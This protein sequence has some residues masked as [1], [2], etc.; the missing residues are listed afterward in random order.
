MQRLIA[1]VAVSAAIYSIDRPY[2][3][4]V[5]QEMTAL[6][7]P[8]QRVIVP[9]GVGNK[10]S[11]GI[12]LE[13]R[14]E[15]EPQRLKEIAH[16][17]E[18][19]AL[20]EE[21]KELALWLCRRTFCTFFQAANVLLPPGIWSKQPE[22]YSPGNVLPEV[23]CV[24]KSAKKQRILKTVFSAE[25]PMTAREIADAS[26]L[27]SIAPD[28]RQL[29]REELLICEHHF[30]QSGREKTIE[31]IS[32]A[33][34][35]EQWAVVLGKKLTA[36]QAAVRDCLLSQDKLP[37]REICYRTG[38]GEGV[39]K[40]LI[41]RQLLSAESFPVSRMP[42][43]PMTNEPPA[44]ILNEEQEKAFEGLRS[45]MNSGKPE[46][47]LLYGVT[48]SGKT[49]IYIKLIR[50]TLQKGKSA[51]LLVPEIALTPQM[52]QK[53]CQFFGDLVAVVHS[54]LTAAQRYEAYQR[55]SIGGAR[56]VIGTRTAVFSPVKDLGCIILDEEQEPS[57]KSDSDPRYHARDVAKYRAAEEK[58]LLLLGSATPSIESFF[59][60]KA[61][62]YHL[63]SLRSRY[64]NTPLPKTL[65]AD[66][67]GQ[68]RSGDPS[69]ISEMLQEELQTNLN[70][71]EQS[72]LFLN[73]RGSARMAACVDCGYIPMCENC[74]SA[75]TYHS[76]NNRLMCHLC[77]YS[78]PMIDTCPECGS[79]HIRLIGFGTQSVEDELQALLPGV[80]IL[81][82]DAD[83]T[84]GRASHEKLLSSFAKGEADILLGTQM[85]AKG[86]DF[87]NV[88]LVGVLDAD[89]SL[90]CGDF[91][92]QERTFSLLT[93]V[94]GRAGRREKPGRAVIQTYTPENPVILAASQQDYDAFY[95]QEI[96]TRRVLKA[97][98]FFE[99][100]V[101]RFSGEDEAAVHRSAARFAQ[102]LQEQLMSVG[103]AEKTV[104]GPVPAAVA[105][106]SRRYYDTVSFRGHSTP[107]SRAFTAK[108]L[109]A[110]QRIH[111]G[112]TAAVSADINPLY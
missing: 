88:T 48:G 89:L 57:Y 26:G 27:E 67:R 18:E 104:L 85:V 46:A 43:S 81:R 69:R 58:C 94:I 101:F 63:F 62:K 10:L 111:T 91:H 66:M 68:L 61:G 6:V 22:T 65:I 4:S 3:Y 103:D 20:S 52:V 53:F 92:A 59:A 64:Q 107:Q 15:S 16:V 54:G 2:D 42:V 5:P 12:I 33:L 110:A 39:V 60:A 30:R 45:L 95:G 35:P 70:N 84:E 74:A 98:P 47:A 19:I 13:L 71:G 31:M 50:E 38:V 44:L 40:T 83:T 105:R 78:R 86:L 21:Q 24:G 49:Q 80:R 82:M 97:P 29:C 9:F 99:Q 17:F 72:I 77:G 75:L 1:R 8:G 87:P 34:P 112:R 23:A 76:R 37:L 41:K 96:E 90:Y 14:H 100:F 7:R 51:M 108:M 106:V 56:V 73:R 109:A 102:L 36:K 32:F 25:R 93:Q 28:L 11:D 79:G 55:I